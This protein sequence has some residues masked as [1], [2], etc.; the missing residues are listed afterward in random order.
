MLAA[1]M[2]SRWK[3]RFDLVSAIPLFQSRIARNQLLWMAQLAAN[4]R[5]DN[6]ERGLVNLIEFQ[7]TIRTDDTWKED[8]HGDRRE[9]F[10]D[11]ERD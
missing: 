8:T 4:G 1:A 9:N 6:R 3:D 7:S 5:F 2:F 10:A 11:L